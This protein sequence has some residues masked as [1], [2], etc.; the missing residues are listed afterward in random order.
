MNTA[1]V[2]TQTKSS[3]SCNATKTWLIISTDSMVR[4]WSGQARDQQ[5][6]FFS[7]CKTTAA[8]VLQLEILQRYDDRAHVTACRHSI[9]ISTL[10]LA[11]TI[12]PSS[13]TFTQTTTHH[14]VVSKRNFVWSDSHIFNDCIFRPWAKP[15]HFVQ[16]RILAHYIQHHKIYQVCDVFLY[17]KLLEIPY[18]LVVSRE[19]CWRPPR[20]H[21]C[22]S[23]LL[24]SAE[25]L[26]KKNT[27]D[28]ASH[29]WHTRTF[30]TPYNKI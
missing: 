7:N 13:H 24:A 11:F 6:S 5:A 25:S 28:K 30:S 14:S 12:S 21:L 3:D 1:A 26:F 23:D 9:I 29:A 15:R 10:C 22:L 20:K 27:H 19:R 17:Q 16:R 4:G 8:I 2:L 18:S